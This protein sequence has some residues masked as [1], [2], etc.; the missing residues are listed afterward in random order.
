MHQGCI[1]IARSYSF[2]ETISPDFRRRVHL[3][4]KQQQPPAFFWSMSIH[5]V[6]GRNPAPPG[7]YKTL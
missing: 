4:E 1:F 6:D 2:T 7:M 5:T 3:F